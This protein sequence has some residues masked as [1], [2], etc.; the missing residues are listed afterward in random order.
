MTKAVCFLNLGGPKTT[1]DV[2]SFLLNLFK[3][4]D[5][6]KLPFQKYSA[7]VI[8]KRRSSRIEAQYRKIGGGS[9]ISDWTTQQGK[10]LESE[11]LKSQ[12]VIKSY[13]GF[14]YT[15]PYTNDMI[16]EMQKD[17]VKE[18]IAFSQYPQYSCSTTGSSLNELYRQLSV[19]DPQK[20]IKWSIIDRWYD[21]PLLIQSFQELIQAALSKY[22]SPKD[23]ED[24]VILFSAHSLPLDNILRGDTY[25]AEVST[26]SALV[27]KHFNNPWSF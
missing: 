21:E 23:Q 11:L 15:P 25:S 12:V 4:E 10:L 13:I 20:S 9:P 19:L 17:G 7:P 6:I 14:R 26:T 5:I 18:A 24:V 8:A 22:Y 2:Q 27:M 16:K 3:D 1:K